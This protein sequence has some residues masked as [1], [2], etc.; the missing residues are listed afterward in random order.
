MSPVSADAPLHTSCVG[1]LTR[2]RAPSPQQEALRCD[3]L[4]HLDSHLDGWA[5]ECAGAHLT[6]SSLI[7]SPQASSV[8][9]TLHAKLGRWLQTGGH[10]EVS[11]SSLAAAARREASEESGLSRL[12]LDPDPLK[13]SRHEVPCGVV[14]PTYHL[15]VQYLVLAD[16]TEQP[17]VSEESTDV[18]WFDVH[19]LPQIDES[20]AELIAAA[21][22]RLR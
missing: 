3:Y 7:C 13:L 5:R 18:R 10:I 17:Q 9:L 15:D 20:V 22:Q 6:A 19:R 21:Q 12:Q 8:L 1:L 2:W 4:A 16:P 11:D 14:R